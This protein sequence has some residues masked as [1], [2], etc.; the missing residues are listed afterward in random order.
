MVEVYT[1]WPSP[2]NIGHAAMMVS[3]GT[4]QQMYLSRWPGSLGAALAM[5]P[6][7]DNR[8]QDDVSSEGGNPSVV[9]LDGLDE[10]SMRDAVVAYQ[11]SN[12][13]SFFALNCATQVKMCL[14]AGVPAYVQIA[15]FGLDLGS[16]PTCTPWGLYAWAKTLAAAL[17]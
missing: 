3:A 12:L 14:N 6:G 11:K 8:Y 17:Y 13:Y 10:D 2:P 5:G 7:L 16:G 15:S 9:R 1:W 4:S